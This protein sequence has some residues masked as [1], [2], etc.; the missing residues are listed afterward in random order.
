MPW[1]RPKKCQKDKKKKK[2]RICPCTSGW[3]VLEGLPAPLRGLL[4]G[5][6]ERLRGDPEEQLIQ[7]IQIA[8]SASALNSGISTLRYLLMW[9][10]FKDV[11]PTTLWKSARCNMLNIG[12]MVDLTLWMAATCVPPYDTS[13]MFAK[14]LRL[15]SLSQN[16]LSLSLPASEISC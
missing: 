10:F 1:E 16:Y 4:L 7:S 11:P 9:I 3:L 13:K 15:F 12:T 2:K 5:S 14:R 6:G 8:Q